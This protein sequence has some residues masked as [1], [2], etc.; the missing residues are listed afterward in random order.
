ME[1]LTHLT[2]NLWGHYD[3][4]SDL[5]QM[6]KSINEYRTS[7]KFYNEDCE[8]L[9]T[10]K[11]V[12]AFH[13]GKNVLVVFTIGTEN[14]IEIQSHPFEEGRFCNLFEKDDCFNIVNEGITIKLKDQP[15]IY[16]KQ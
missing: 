13:R 14:E 11:E 5:Y 8:L 7:S 9:Y 4:T 2:E 12:L 6:I 10:S 1:G 16:T 3:T 15:K